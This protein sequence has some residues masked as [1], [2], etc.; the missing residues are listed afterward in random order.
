MLG[1]RGCRQDELRGIGIGDDDLRV[2]EGPHVD[3]EDAAQVVL[4]RHVGVD[5]LRMCE[6]RQPDVS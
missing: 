2:E 1:V 5:M 4:L 6:Q 3:V